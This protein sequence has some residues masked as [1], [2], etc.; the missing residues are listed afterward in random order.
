[1]CLLFILKVFRS[2]TF[3]PCGLFIYAFYAISYVS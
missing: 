2:L 3:S 1:M